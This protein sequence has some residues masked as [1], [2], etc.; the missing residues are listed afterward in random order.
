MIIAQYQPSLI[1]QLSPPATAAVQFQALSSV[2]GT[3][4]GL[5][6]QPSN[7]AG[8]VNLAIGQGFLFGVPFKL[9]MQGNATIVTTATTLTMGVQLGTAAW[10][11]GAAPATMFA[12]NTVA[13]ASL[14]AGKHSFVVVYDLMADP[15]TQ[16]V[17]GQTTVVLYDNAIPASS[18]GVVIGNQVTGLALPTYANPYAPYSWASPI[19]GLDGAQVAASAAG[20]G[21]QNAPFLFAVPQATFGTTSGSSTINLMSFIVQQ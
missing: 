13:S 17:S 9:T 20:D 4:N 14:S 10:F 15:L 5:P 19:T 16:T 11:S 3:P 6:Q 1:A 18:E 2:G 8:N 7:K 21:P 12:E